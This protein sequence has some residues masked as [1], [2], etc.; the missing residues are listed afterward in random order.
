MP[1]AA[2]SAPGYAE[3]ASPKNQRKV[4]DI[5]PRHD[6]RDGPFFQKLFPR[7]PLLVFDQF[8]LNDGHDAAESLQGEQGKGDEEVRP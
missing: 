7:E 6:L 5:R 3:V 1:L 2:A 8:L 4:D